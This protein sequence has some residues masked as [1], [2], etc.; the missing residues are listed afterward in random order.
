MTLE[1]VGRSLQPRRGVAYHVRFRGAHLDAMAELDSE[2]ELSVDSIAV[3]EAPPQSWEGL[4]HKQQQGSP[5]QHAAGKGLSSAQVSLTPALQQQLAARECGDS[6]GGSGLLRIA[7]A[8]EP[9]AGRVAADSADAYMLTAPG[10]ASDETVCPAP[11]MALEGT[12]LQ[13]RLSQVHASGALGLPSESREWGSGDGAAVAEKLA[14]T[15]LLNR[16]GSARA[17]HLGAAAGHSPG[18]ASSLDAVPASRLLQPPDVPVAPGLASGQSSMDGTTTTTVSRAS[19]SRHQRRLTSS[20]SPAPGSSGGGSSARD[21][22]H[23]D[24]P[25]IEITGQSDRRSMDSSAGSLVPNASSLVVLFVEP[26]PRCGLAIVEVEAPAGLPDDDV[27]DT[28]KPTDVSHGGSGPNS[29]SS[30]LSGASDRALAGTPAEA[31]PSTA[32]GPGGGSGGGGV[33]G[34]VSALGVGVGGSRLAAGPVGPAKPVLSDWWPVVVLPRGAELAA[35]ELNTLT[36]EPQT[37]V[38][39]WV[40]SSVYRGVARCPSPAVRASACVQTV[41]VDASS[42]FMVSICGTLRRADMHA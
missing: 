20:S 37:S 21:G 3:N 29:R 9:A 12:G 10:G 1:L 31:L 27:A 42:L 35:E 39:W 6:A 28:A 4:Q 38:A 17:S 41:R 32:M 5:P 8:A 40:L 19:L 34:P 11:D 25:T 18:A 22:S 30:R 7:P 23:P 14:G 13:D 15:F 33:C 24:P 2:S 16:E 36:E 26:A